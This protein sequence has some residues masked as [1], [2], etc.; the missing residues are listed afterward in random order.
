MYELGSHSY[1]TAELI[2]KFFMSIMT[3]FTPLAP[4]TRCS[5]WPLSIRNIAKKRLSC[6]VLSS[7]YTG[8]CCRE[9]WGPGQI[10]LVLGY[11]YRLCERR[12]G[13][14]PHEVLGFIHAVKSVLGASVVPFC[15]CIQDIHT[16]KLSSVFSDFK[17]G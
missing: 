1:T 4:P 15:A 17:K 12:L 5:I 8:I 9:D 7:S 13:T 11:E 2:A 10:Q 3:E 14:P 6:T 16:F